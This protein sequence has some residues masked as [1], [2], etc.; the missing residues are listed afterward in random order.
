M[1]QKK[2]GDEA[3]RRGRPRAYD[4]EE[5]LRRAMDAFWKSGYSGTSLDDLSAA[6]GMNRP[7]LYAAFGDKRSLYLKA[8]AYYWQVALGTMRA[9]LA[10]D[11]PLAD[12]LMR[13]YEGALSIYFSGDDRPRGCFVVGTAVTEAMEDAEIRESLMTGFLEFDADFEA[14]FRMARDNGELREDA[15]PATLATL[16]TAVMHTIAIRA[17]TGT[18]R[19]DLA[20]F[21]RKAV[22]AI[23]G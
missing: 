5:A 2:D 17:R 13:A 19:A 16:A 23:C 15:D 3:K 10:Q 8:L 7:S 1:V 21:A 12:S 22:R 18:P 6:T 11:R 20:E 9:D 14:R 4:P